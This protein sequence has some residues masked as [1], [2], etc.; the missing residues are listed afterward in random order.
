MKFVC[1]ES[2]NSQLPP[3]GKHQV[4]IVSGIAIPDSGEAEIF[5]RFDAFLSNLPSSSFKDGEPKGNLLHDASRKALPAMLAFIHSLLHVSHTRRM[6][7]SGRSVRHAF[8]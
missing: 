2:G 4:G 6:R 8:R 3:A 5:R 7:I 1:D